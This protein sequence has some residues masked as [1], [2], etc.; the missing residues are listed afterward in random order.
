MSDAELISQLAAARLLPVGDAPWSEHQRWLVEA[1]QRLINL[2]LATSGVVRLARLGWDLAQAVRDVGPRLM[3]LHISDN[4]GSE[5]RHWLPFE[6]VIDWPAFCSALKEAGYDGP[7]MY[8]VAAADKP[9]A[10]R[11]A[12]VKANYDRVMELS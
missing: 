12:E 5:E 8:E 9:L 10:M 1:G 7:L 6:G 2:G 4:D 3:A 11:V